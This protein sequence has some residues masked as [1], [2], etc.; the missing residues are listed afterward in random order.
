LKAAIELAGTDKLESG[1]QF[2]RDACANLPEG[3]DTPQLAAAKQLLSA[4]G[5]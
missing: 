2:L 5:S 1:A 3:F 4:V